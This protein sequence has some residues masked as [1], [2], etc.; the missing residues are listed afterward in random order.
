MKICF[1]SQRR[2]AYISHA[3]AIVLKKKY[4]VAEFCAYAQLRSSYEFL[5]NQTDIKYT[6]LILDEDIHNGFKNEPLDLEY[7][8]NLEQKYGFPNLWHC[9]T[10]DRVLMHS[11]MIREYP[12]NNPKYSHEEMLRIVQ[13]QAKT[14]IKFLDEEKPSAVIFTVVG[15]VGSMLLYQIAKK[16]GI[17]T[18]VISETRINDECTLT[19]DY[20]NLSWAEET[21]NQLKI[22]GAASPSAKKAQIYLAK[23]RHNPLACLAYWAEADVKKPKN[24][25]SNYR[26]FLPKNFFDSWRWFIKTIVRY[27][28][29]KKHQDYAEGTPWH[30]FLDRLKRKLRT[31][32]G[33]EHLYDKADF[34]EDYAFFPLH[35]EPEITT[36]LFA[37]FWTDQ[38]NLI[39]QIARSLPV[40]FKLYVKEHPSMLGYRPHSYYKELKKIPNVKLIDPDI[41]SFQIIANAKLITVITGTTGWEAV[42]LKKPVITFGDVFYNCLPAVKRCVQIEQLPYLVQEQLKNFQDDDATLINFIGSIMEVSLPANLSKVWSSGIN[43]SRDQQALTMLADLIARKLNLKPINK[44]AG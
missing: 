22:T 18:L 34:R 1:F 11:Q 35:L 4:G 12:Y 9:L 10:V 24:R 29:A 27:F 17:L 39:K 33:F 31:L 36:M 26:W 6:S 42:L 21:F 23:F 2:F 28:A 20:K 41:T 25:W 5:R 44:T 19:E 3:I 14:I 43:K 40:H 30:Y 38:I 32:I 37:P 13:V 16:K 15:C 7:L 8:K